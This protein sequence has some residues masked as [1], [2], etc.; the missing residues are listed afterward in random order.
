MDNPE[1]PGSRARA[2]DELFVA[3]IDHILAEESVILEGLKAAV[4]AGRITEEE[5]QEWLN[6][7]IEKRNMGVIYIPLTKPED[8]ST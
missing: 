1:K 2:E 7:Y 5:K 3:R 4:R 8:P 6:S